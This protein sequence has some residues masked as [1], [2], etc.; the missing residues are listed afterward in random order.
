MDKNDSS[1]VSLNETKQKKKEIY[2]SSSGVKKNSK[3]YD[4]FIFLFRVGER[5]RRSYFAS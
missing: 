1:Y 3:T 4:G 5:L 2:V